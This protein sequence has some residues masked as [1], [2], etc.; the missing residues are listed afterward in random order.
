MDSAP[1]LSIDPA[2]KYSEATVADAMGSLILTC[3]PTTPLIAVARRMAEQRVPAI[4]VLTAGSVDQRWPWGVV[5]DADLIRRADQ[6][7]TLTA[8]EVASGDALLAHPGEP[9]AAAA[10]R[11]AAS[12][13]THAL[14]VD[15]TTGR[16][17]GVLSSLEVTRVIARGTV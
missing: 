17:V 6:V 5:T 3:E 14:V 8:G 13:A 11:L 12:A 16:P 10:R 4:V 9:L 1:A 7:A 15:Q 2:P